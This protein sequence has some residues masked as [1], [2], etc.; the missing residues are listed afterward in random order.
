M[1]HH[2][3]VLL[4]TIALS[5]LAQANAVPATATPSSP[6]IRAESTLEA[7]LR[8]IFAI[9]N[10]LNLLYDT[11]NGTSVDDTPATIRAATAQLRPLCTQ[12]Q[13][14]PTPQLHQLCLLADAIIWQRDWVYCTYL[15]EHG[16][17]LDPADALGLEVPARLADKATHRLHSPATTAEEKAAWAELLSL[18][19]GKTA[20]P[21]PR[22]L[23]QSR[24]AK[25]YKTAL[26]FFK[27]LCAA[28]AQ[29]DEA[30]SIRSIREQAGVLDYLLQ[31]GEAD[32]L[33]LTHL[34]TAFAQAR[35]NLRNDGML[36]QDEAGALQPLSEARRQAL[37]P[38]FTRLPALRELR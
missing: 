36:P 27:D 19:G 8:T 18:F 30:Q 33:R 26:T 6:G 13:A 17:T 31:C 23:L 21:I 9:Q 10:E 15:A 29:P 24:R 22:Q 32:R 16:I 2:L 35:Q 14:L 12:L 7:Q 38:I 34:L 37:E 25:D 28:A 1:K 11:C 4:A 20:L 3:L 5:T